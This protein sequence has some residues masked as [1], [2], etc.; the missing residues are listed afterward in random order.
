[1]AD[2]EKPNTSVTVDYAAELDELASLRGGI[3][4][5]KEAKDA[6][7]QGYPYDEK[8]S[9]KEYEKT[10]RKLQIELLKLQLWVKERGE[11][12]CIIFE[13]RD[14]A[15]KGG[16][17]KRFT[18]HLN[19]VARAWWRWRNPPRW[20]RRSGISSGTPRICPAA[21]RSC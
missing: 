19:P 16:S 15:G 2:Q 9:R 6:W 12:I 4:R 21:A 13:G 8:L 7:K 17:I 11:K 1:M 14:A 20:N 3:S 18:E 10:K 5:T